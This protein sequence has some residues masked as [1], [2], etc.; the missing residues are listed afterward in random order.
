MPLTS[1]RR[2]SYAELAG[3]ALQKLVMPVPGPH[4]VTWFVSHFWGTSFRHFVHSVRKH[5][6]S[7][8]HHLQ[9]PWQDPTY[10]IC[11]F[12]GSTAFM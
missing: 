9:C 6:E 2:L 4:Q 10:W 1:K 5:A 3:E 12:S 7:V 8:S 11:S